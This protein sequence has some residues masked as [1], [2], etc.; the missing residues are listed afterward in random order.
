MLDIIKLLLIIIYMHFFRNWFSS[1]RVSLFQ[2]RRTLVCM[3]ISVFYAARNNSKY[4]F[5]HEIICLVTQD[6]RNNKY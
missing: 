5:I 4:I 3:Y 6:E 2:C 1:S